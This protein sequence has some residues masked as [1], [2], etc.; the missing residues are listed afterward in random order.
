M[1]AIVQ[2]QAIAS[3]T[4]ITGRDMAWLQGPRTQTVYRTWLSATTVNASRENRFLL[5]QCTACDRNRAGRADWIRPLPPNGAGEVP[6]HVS[7]FDV[8][9]L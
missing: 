9:H 5:P 6:A 1:T 7:P 3:E 8:F 2:P 4:N